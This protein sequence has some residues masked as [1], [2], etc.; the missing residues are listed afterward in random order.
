MLPGDLC[1]VHSHTDP[2]SVW[3]SP[4]LQQLADSLDRPQTSVT[5]WFLLTSVQ[6]LE[7]R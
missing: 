3:K 1:V 5:L 7:A 4:L 2:L 6:P